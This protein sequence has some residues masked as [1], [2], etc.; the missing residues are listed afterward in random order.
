MLCCSEGTEQR[1]LASDA[2]S[3]KNPYKKIHALID[4]ESK[5]GAW[6][7]WS[8]AEEIKADALLVSNVIDRV[9][10]FM[11]IL[12]AQMG[13]VAAA[14]QETI[15]QKKQAEEGQWSEKDPSWR[16]FLLELSK[17][18]CQLCSLLVEMMSFS[19]KGR[20]DFLQAC[21]A[22]I[23]EAQDD[24]DPTL[25]DNAYLGSAK[26]IAL[27]TGNDGPKAQRRHM[28]GRIAP[29]YIRLNNRENLLDVTSIALPHFLPALMQL[30]STLS[31][32]VGWAD[33]MKGKVMAAGVSV[34]FAVANIVF[35]H[36]SNALFP[37]SEQGL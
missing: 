26:G 6:Y 5:R 35:P 8:H 36:I 9:K 2:E 13:S 10:G 14:D 12:T 16:L 19:Q 25:N 3:K 28:A 11:D 32:Q 15:W 7:M 1:L 27:Y 29:A 30:Q 23:Y 17:A 31:A 24:S 37:D 33:S 22:D 20:F 18:E 34:G 21:V 4:E